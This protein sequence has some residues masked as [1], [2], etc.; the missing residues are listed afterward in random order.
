MT[1][2]A[3]SKCIVALIALATIAATPA[4]QAEPGTRLPFPFAGLAWMPVA[5]T[6]PDMVAFTGHMPHLDTAVPT[7]MQTERK[8][9]SQEPEAC[10][11]AVVTGSMTPSFYQR[12]TRPR[13]DE[14]HA[15]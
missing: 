5:N 13:G 12:P 11:Y 14:S 9:S 1:L 3:R 6:A 2:F 7:Q 10:N 8:L 4:K 15:G